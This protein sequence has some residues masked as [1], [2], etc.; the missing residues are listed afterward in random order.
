MTK[1][2]K[3]QTV[4][5]RDPRTKH[6][7]LLEGQ[8]SLPEFEYLAENSWV[9]TEKVDGTNIR[10]YYKDGKVIFKG[11]TDNSQIPAELF[12][13]LTEKFFPQLDAM[14]SIFD[15]SEVVFYGEGYGNNIQKNGDNYIPDQ[16]FVLFDINID[17]WWLKRPNVEGIAK[18]LSLNVVP[19][20]GI[21]TLPEMVERAR[22][23]IK[24]TWGDFQA[25][26]IVART[27][28]ELKTRGGQRMI[29]K[30]KT[31]DFK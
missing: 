24:S 27:E 28:A 12:N 5:K 9:F 13:K 25:E 20:I 7:T 11:R 3:I 23:G 8:Y 15:N 29:T 2:H 26:G 18:A 21:G 6:K 30:I 19:I 4:F 16:D 1:Y 14:K 17:G 10:V 22:K 31:K